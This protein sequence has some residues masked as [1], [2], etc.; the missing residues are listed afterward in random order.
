MTTVRVTR[1]F[2]DL[3][4]VLPGGDALMRDVGD[5][6][7]RLIADRTRQGIDMHGAPFVPLS[8]GYAKQKQKHLGHS[9]ADLQVSGR[10][11]NDMQVV[12]ATEHTV[13]ISFISQGGTAT[14]TTFIQ[15][16]RSVGAADKAF[17]HNDGN[18]GVVREFFGLTDSEEDRIATVV[19]EALE[20]R[21]DAL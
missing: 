11:L 6:A 16:S 20:R 2:G 4:E 8:A 7:V 13:E 9:R 18:H 14:G 12:A 5:L 1:N 21:I 15:R 19:A 10:M 3:R 17:F